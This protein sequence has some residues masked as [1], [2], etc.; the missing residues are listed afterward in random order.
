MILDTPGPNPRKGVYTPGEP[1]VGVEL[2]PCGLILWLT[3]TDDNQT[4]KL[5]LP[6]RAW[7]E[8]QIAIGSLLAEEAERTRISLAVQQLID[9]IDGPGGEA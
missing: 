2:D 9:P 3:M 7:G 4:W 6:R 1:V 5:P 8:I